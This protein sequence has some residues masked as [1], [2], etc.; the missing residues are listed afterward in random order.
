MQKRTFENL[1]LNGEDCFLEGDITIFGK[2]EIKD[3][4]LIV[5]GS[6]TISGKSN[7]EIE[8][9][10]IIVSDALTIDTD[11]DIDININGGNISCGLLD[12][13]NINITD[14]D[15]WTNTDLEASNIT[16][17]GNIEVKGT[18][19]VVDVTCLNYLITGD[20][21]SESINASQDIYILGNNDSCDLTARE[22]L[23]DGNCDANDF[24]I[25]AHHFV[26]NGELSCEGFFI[27]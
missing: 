19:H 3:A 27:V 25:I 6:I 20:N 17:D 8:N 4:N 9:G 10:D 16:S 22:I 2:L 26:C 7:V 21:D 13:R 11:T 15:I 18:S 1:I 5:S 24:P 12:C 23:I 14:G